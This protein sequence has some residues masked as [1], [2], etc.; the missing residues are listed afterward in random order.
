MKKN[1]DFINNLTPKP[2]DLDLEVA[3]PRKDSFQAKE[4]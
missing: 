2:S 1:A 4:S 3:T